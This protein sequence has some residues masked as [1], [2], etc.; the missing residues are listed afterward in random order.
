MPRTERN[1]GQTPSGDL[2]MT[3]DSATAVNAFTAVKGKDRSSPAVH[4]PLMV[5]AAAVILALF[6]VRITIPESTTAAGAPSTIS[7]EKA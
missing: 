5:T 1:V 4:A 7:S 6:S 3:G 2:V